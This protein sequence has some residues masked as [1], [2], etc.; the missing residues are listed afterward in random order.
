MSTPQPQRELRYD[1]IFPFLLGETPIDGIW[2]G[3]MPLGKSA[4]WWRARLRSA[5]EEREAHTA[6]AVRE[7]VSKVL[8]H[9]GHDLVEKSISNSDIDQ[10]LNEILG[11]TE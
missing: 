7:A 11:G 1:D 3:E 9:L 8:E 6:A 5:L 2:F 10:L 4:F